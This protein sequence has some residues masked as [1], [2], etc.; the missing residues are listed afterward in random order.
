VGNANQLA[1]LSQK[2]VPRSFRLLVAFGVKAFGIGAGRIT[3][4]TA[5]VA[6]ALFHMMQSLTGS[7]RR[8]VE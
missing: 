2:Y 7:R 3:P 4:Y 1:R 5:A 8:G 6:F